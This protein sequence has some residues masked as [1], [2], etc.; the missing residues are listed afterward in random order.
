MNKL[1]LE[2]PTSFNISYPRKN[3]KYYTQYGKKKILPQLM[4]SCK[5]FCMYCGKT[6]RTESDERYNIE[7][8]VDKEGNLHQTDKSVAV[9]SNCKYNLAISCPE[10]NLVCK[11]IIDKI[12]VNKYSPIPNCPNE[13]SSPCDLF[14]EIRKDYM[15]KNTIILQPR[16]VDKNNKYKIY[17]NLLKHIFVTSCDEKND[18]IRFFIQNHID[19]FELNGRRFT[20]SIINICVQ[21]VTWYDNGMKNGRGLLDTLIMEQE[22]GNIHNIMGNVFTDFLLNTFR[23]REAQDMVDFCRMLVLLDAIL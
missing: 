1:D 6:I 19:R 3:I 17:Y 5:G 15:K 23:G 22:M 13:C 4:S 2:F 14:L 21:V 11:K 9:L 16:Q 12:D 7:H 18:A 10:C 20:L 8:A